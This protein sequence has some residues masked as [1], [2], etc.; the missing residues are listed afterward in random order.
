MGA[1]NF[2]SGTGNLD[3]TPEGE[4]GFGSRFA[5]LAGMLILELDGAP[6]AEG[7][8]EPSLVVNLVDEPRKRMD[9]VGE[10]LIASQIDLFD[11][12]R[13]HE[14]FRLRV[15]VGVATPAHGTAEPV[16]RQEVAIGLGSVLC[17]A[18]RMMNAPSRRSTA[19]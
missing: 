9:D 14:A 1:G 5:S 18:I 17:P 19:L 15:V 11:L 3:C 2:F 16:G 10:G 4:Q 13:L 7:G 6:V 8:M 12:Q